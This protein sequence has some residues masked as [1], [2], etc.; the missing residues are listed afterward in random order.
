M[1]TVACIAVLWMCAIPVF[2]QKLTATAVGQ[3]PIETLCRQLN[4]RSESAVS[5]CVEEMKKQGPTAEEDAAERLRYRAE[6]GK[7][8]DESDEFIRRQL[9]MDTARGYR[10]V[11]IETYAK[12]VDS[13]KPGDRIAV[14]GQLRTASIISD[15]SGQYIGYVS[16]NHAS[17]KVRQRFLSILGSPVSMQG[18]PT[19]VVLLGRIGTCQHIVMN[20]DAGQVPCLGIEDLWSMSDSPGSWTFDQMRTLSPIRDAIAR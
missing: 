20:V 15:F 19:P 9:S 5:V 11:M 16:I 3:D 10:N 12:E 14:A 7:A 4:G 18:G 8:I 2:G 6:E 13:L 1:K 17:L